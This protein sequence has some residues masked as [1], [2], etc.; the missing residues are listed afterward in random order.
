MATRAM[1]VTVLVA[2]AACR[3][4]KPPP[5]PAPPTERSAVAMR[6]LA[7]TMKPISRV[8]KPIPPPERRRIIYVPERPAFDPDVFLPDPTPIL[9]WPLNASSHPEL[10]PQF[11]IASA[12]AE[13]GLDWIALC[14]LGAHRRQAGRA[15]RDPIGYLGAW[16]AVA[17]H[18]TDTAIARF[19]SLTR[20]TVAGLAPAVRQDITNVLVDHGTVDDAVRLL[21]KYRIR[22]L[23][24]LDLLAATYLDVGRP[25]DAREVNEL[26]IL[27]DDVNRANRCRRQARRV[28]MNPDPYRPDVNSGLLLFDEPKEA[29]RTCDRL[30]AQLACWLRP[31]RDCEP[32]FRASG[33]DPRAQL[34]IQAHESWPTGPRNGFAWL[35]TADFAIH[36]GTVARAYDFAVLALETAVRSEDC[37]EWVDHA[38][39]HRARSLLA[40]PDRPT[41]FESR[42]RILAEDPDLLCD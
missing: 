22:D 5:P 21:S 36:A 18:D 8:S 25:D 29:D 15:L 34:L 10:A 13:P 1:A 33:V 42:L 4:Q 20:S 9:R 2:L 31:K 30:E 12:L 40:E 23:A 35:E 41:G 38:V 39:K 6:A 17:D 26:A 3:A 24:V 37:S 19:A 11:E 7:A 28:V 16:C 27:R 14:R 32:H